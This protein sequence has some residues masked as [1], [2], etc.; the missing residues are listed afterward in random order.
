MK[1]ESYEPKGRPYN[2]MKTMDNIP[3][4]VILGVPI[5]M[6]TGNFELVLENIKGI[7]EYSKEIIKFKIK[8]GEL[9][10]SGN[11]LEIVHYKNT[12]IK[13]IG[14]INHIEYNHERNNI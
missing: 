12:D 10:I 8:N 7:I 3:K 5:L 2:H 9:I 4:D 14:H 1:R 6:L 13:I 11:H